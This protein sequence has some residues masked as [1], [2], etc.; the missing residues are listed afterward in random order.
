MSA[1]VH[2]KMNKI[3]QELLEN[4]K[5]LFKNTTANMNRAE[6]GSEEEMEPLPSVPSG[7]SI[8][9]DKADVE[10]LH[11]AL[12][13]LTPRWKNWTIRT[14]FTLIMI[15]LFGFIIYLGPLAITILILTIQ[16]V[17]YILIFIFKSCF[18]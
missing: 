10:V 8:P 15:S 14:I 2:R 12:K 4:E 9:Q 7:E 1:L 17:L 3:H 6:L 11:A 5:M 16:V 18:N 13:D